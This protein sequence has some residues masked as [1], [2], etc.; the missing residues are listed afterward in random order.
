MFHWDEL[1]CAVDWSPQ[2]HVAMEYAAD[3]AKRLGAKLT[4]VY[5]DPE[6]V[7]SPAH[8]EMLER[9]RVEAGERA[10]SRVSSMRLVGDA[11]PTILQ[12]VRDSGCQL[13]VVGTHGRAGISRLALGSVAEEL[14]R[15]STCPVLVARNGRLL[16]REEDEEEAAQYR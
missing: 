5:V 7:P 1:T 2:S 9:W 11:V 14:V 12:Q 16:R 13:L 3:L 10:G 4:L 6:A 15:R 8:D